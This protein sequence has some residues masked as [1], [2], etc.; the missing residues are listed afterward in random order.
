[1]NRVATLSIALAALAC[2]RSE[3]H[4]SVDAGVVESASQLVRATPAF[5]ELL[6]HARPFAIDGASFRVQTEHL[7]ARIAPGTLHLASEA[8]ELSIDLPMAHPHLDGAAVV[9]GDVLVF[10]TSAGVEELRTLTSKSAPTHFTWRLRPGRG[11][12]ALRLRDERVEALDARGAVRFATTPMFAVDANG[13]RVS[14][15]VALDGDVLTADL[16]NAGLAYPIVVDPAWT[17]TGVVI[18][19]RVFV[20]AVR[21]VD[22]R[23]LAIGGSGNLSELYDPTTGAWS[24]GPTLTGSWYGVDDLSNGTGSGLVR[25]ASGKVLASF[26]TASLYN[27]ATNAWSDAGTLPTLSTFAAPLPGGTRV[28]A[29]CHYLPS[30]ATTAAYIYQE[31]TNA[32]SSAASMAVARSGCSG[33]ALSDGRVLVVG[34][35]NSGG[36]LA[37]GEIYNATTN[38]WSAIAPM[39]A[40]RRRPMVALLTDGRVL[41][42]SDTSYQVYNPSTNAWIATPATL[43]SHASGTMTLLASG[44]V[45]V[46]G[47]VLQ[48]AAEIYDP[49]TNTWTTGGTMASQ[50]AYH[51]AVRLANDRV[52]IGEG[53]RNYAGVSGWTFVGASELYGDTLGATCTAGWECASGNCVEAVCCATASCASG[54][55]CATTAK[56]GTCVYPLGVA[57][58][59]GTQCESGFCVDGVCCNAAC[60]GQCESCD[61]PD[62]LGV[63]WAVLG[64]PRGS[65]PACTGA[66]A[67]TACGDR[68]DGVDR[69]AC[70][71]PGAAAACGSDSC[72]AGVETHSSTCDSSGKCGDVPKSCGSYACG[73]TTCKTSCATKSDCS[74]GY[75]C[76]TNACVA[77]DGLGTAC[78]SAAACSTG[79]CTDNVCCGV[80]DCGLGSSCATEKK[81]SCAKIQGFE[82]AND[83]E[84]GSGHC[85]DGVCCESTCDGQCEACDV[86]GKFGK[87]S[88][89]NGAPHGLRKVCDDG[90]GDACKARTCDGTIDAATCAAYANGPSTACGQSSCSGATYTG[91]GTCDG[92]GACSVAETRA[93]APYAC[94]EAGCRVGCA[95][96]EHCA[97]GFVCAGG[98]CK[99]LVAKCSEDRLSSITK[100]GSTTACTPYRCGPTGECLAQCV[101]SADCAPGAICDAG[102]KVCVAPSI[103]SGDEGGCAMGHSESNASWP[104]LALLALA[105]R[106]RR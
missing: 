48:A 105:T 39:N 74:P 34:G 25:L 23:V 31:T 41:V 35:N 17:A 11:I 75:V 63:C 12:A 78:T 85:V 4:S 89:V 52:L 103:S 64:A 3:E 29:A 104:L 72:V 45:L 82:C 95:R 70:H 94:D 91:A 27:A 87:C 30:S 60:K 84:C 66:G 15:R 19:K 5:V 18:H 50:R 57:C 21:L 90:G 81:G 56:R 79:F 55:S 7:A 97:E 101:G 9:D 69:T 61:Q 20:D 1:M 71:V 8:A 37:S 76:K 44:K 59:T 96:D 102:S 24:A 62:K 42:G 46:A 22:G 6:D 68:C 32:W 43:V 40:A 86:P 73:A 53:A 10:A 33:T 2:A 65:R 99:P 16:D 98:A 58:T 83:L 14:L 93:C 67:G 13:K 47:G 28:L 36:A 51:F 106:R 80:A 49:K 77:A 92:K 88:A 38:T 54:A 100:D 26:Q